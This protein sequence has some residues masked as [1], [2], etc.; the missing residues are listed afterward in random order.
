MTN[1]SDAVLRPPPSLRAVSPVFFLL[2]IGLL[3]PWNAFISAKPYFQARACQ[4]ENLEL[5][6]G[7]VYTISSVLS[8]GFV[9]VNTYLKDI[10]P[11]ATA[12]NT[13][14][15]STTIRA[16]ADNFSDD[17]DDDVYDQNGSDENGEPTELSDSSTTAPF[18]SVVIPLSVYT[19]VFVL[20]AVLVFFPTIP[21]FVTITLLGLSACGIMVGMASAGIVTVANLFDDPDRAVGPHFQGQAMG[22]VAVSIANYLVA[23]AN[24]D[25]A[26]TFYDGH[27]L[28]NDANESFESILASATVVEK[29]V[30]QHR[31][32]RHG[33]VAVEGM[34]NSVCGYDKPDWGTFVYFMTGAIL[35]VACVVGFS[36]I[37]GIQARCAEYSLLNGNGVLLDRD[38][39]AEQGE[40]HDIGLPLST[41]GDD[42]SFDGL[43]DQENE[44]DEEEMEM[45]PEDGI[46]RSDPIHSHEDGAEET[47]T[48][49][50]WRC[51]RGPWLAV[52]LNFVV[53][54]SMFPSWTSTLQ[55]VHQCSSS[56]RIVNDLFVPLTFVI[57][58]L[59]DLSG[60]FLAPL[61][62]NVRSSH[63]V[64]LA[65]LRTIFFGLFYFCNVSSTTATS[66]RYTVMSDAYT[67][68]VEVFFAASNGLLLAVTFMHAPSLLPPTVEM[69][70]RGSEFLNF[71]INFGLLSGSL[72][73]F[74][75]TAIASSA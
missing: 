65:V 50:V 5:W 48:Y 35:L 68:L 70:K 11:T 52:Y 64:G 60:R 69:Q 24:Q 59:S 41:D 53:T 12:R 40:D 51:I 49:Y 20:M 62:H 29:D 27:C 13:T 61:V 25:A 9:I 33:R 32:H 7:L 54:L 37:H 47:T 36:Y 10:W 56:W 1:N 6:F 46:I 4:F 39:S 28:H 15:P 26:S 31:Y 30:G 58:N 19:L 14:T 22:G 44:Q 74:V 38:D 67:V 3:V 57:F 73:S 23:W 63:L 21:G 72:S 71:A 43:N 55:S 16:N 34:T 17:D 2:G 45:E 18:W 66:D 42:I 8:L 75:Y